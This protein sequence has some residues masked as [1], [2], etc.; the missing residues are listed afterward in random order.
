MEGEIFPLAA[1]RNGLEVTR[2]FFQVGF[3]YI[4]KM[5]DTENGNSILSS[6]YQEERT[7][8][9]SHGLKGKKWLSLNDPN[10]LG[11][12]LYAVEMPRCMGTGF[13]TLALLS[14]RLT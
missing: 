3:P 7:H 9:V 11:A 5:Q 4:G 10:K 6:L 1:L 8:S 14:V 2:L 13:F 12:N